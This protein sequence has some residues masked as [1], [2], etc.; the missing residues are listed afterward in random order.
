MAVKVKDDVAT[1]I[2]RDLD[3]IRLKPNLYLTSQGPARIFHCARELIQNNFDEINNKNSNGNKIDI[4]YDI[5]TD[6]LT[7]EDDGR[8]FSEAEISLDIFC[9][10]M[11]SGTKF[12][13]DQG[14]A[15]NGEL[16]N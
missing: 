11:Q 4:T 16:T 12:F 3:R 10:H 5:A 7:V 14:G 8:G 6:I 9:E 2:E 1:Y 13:R 15:T